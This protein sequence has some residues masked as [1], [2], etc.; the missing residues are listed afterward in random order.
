MTGHNSS[1][2]QSAHIRVAK[3]LGAES[4]VERCYAENGTEYKKAVHD[5]LVFTKA[6]TVTVIDDGKRQNVPDLAFGQAVRQ[7]MVAGI[8]ITVVGVITGIGMGGG[9]I[10][11]TARAT[12]NTDPRSGPAV[13]GALGPC[14]VGLKAQ[15]R[16]SIETGSG[17]RRDGS[18]SSRGD[19]HGVHRRC[20]SVKGAP[21][22]FY[23][24]LWFVLIAF[25]RK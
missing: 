9:S 25:I 11:G 23:T 16:M 5:L 22:Q 15:R 4:L 19:G 12:A 14:C 13:D 6:F 10:D 3:E 7:T 24:Q 18:G 21:N 1:A 2:M 17:R 8:V 20:V